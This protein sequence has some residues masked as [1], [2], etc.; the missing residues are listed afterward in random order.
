MSEAIWFALALLGAWMG[1]HAISA[2]VVL[3][4]VLRLQLWPCRMDWL[5]PPAGL[6]EDQFAAVDEVKA[7]GFRS[8]AE[9]T[10][11]VGPRRYGSFLFRH[12]D[13]PVFAQLSLQAGNTAGYPLSFHSFCTDGTEL[14]TVNRIGWLIMTPLPRQQRLDAWAD[15]LDAHWK[16]HQ[17]RLANNTVDGITDEAAQH[18]IGAS[19]ESYFPLLRERGLLV[20]EAGAWHPRLRT[21]AAVTWRWLKIRSHFARPYA[22]AATSDAH[23][24]AFYTSSYIET[25][26]ALASRPARNNVKAMLLVLTAAASLLLWGST[27]NWQAGLAL[28]VILLLHEGGHALAMRAFG[29]RDLTMFF[30]P[31]IG[32]VVTGTPRPLPAWKQAVVLLAG[33]VP[34]MLIGLAMLLWW[35]PPL[36]GFDWPRAATLAVAVNLFNLLPVTPLDG[37]RLVELSLFSRWPRLRLV[38]AA[39][40]VAALA[41]LALWSKSPLMWVLVIALGFGLLSQWRIAQLQRAWREG[42]SQE[43]QLPHL[44]EAARRTFGSQG[45]IRQYGLVKAVLTQRA[46]AIPRAWESVVTLSILLAL[47]TT[48][49]VAAYPW[50][51]SQSSRA[52]PVGTAEQQAF[53]RAYETFSSDYGDDRDKSLKTLR[54]QAARLAPEDPRQVDMQIVLA[55]EAEG[56]KRQQAYEAVLAARKNGHAEDLESIQR[57]MLNEVY[58]DHHGEAPQQRAAALEAAI[59]RAGELMPK[60]YA[61]TVEGRLRLAEAIDQ[62]GDAQRA[63]SM[64]AEIRHRVETADDCRCEL[65]KVLSAQAWFFLGQNRPADAITM[66]ESSSH[67]RNLK[68]PNGSLADEYAWALLAAGRIDEGIAQMRIAAYSEASRPGLRQR[69]QG[70]KDRPAELREP[71][72]LAYALR[73]GGRQQEAAALLSPSA[74]W[75]C[76]RILGDQDSISAYTEPW[77]QP[78]ERRLNDTARAICP[79]N[80]KPEDIWPES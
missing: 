26:A 47:W 73:R 5:T 28:L 53:D 9:G 10:V 61:A 14:L 35:T 13:L 39:L 50:L 58:N 78:R 32:A 56:A 8:I 74:L 59:A 11:E 72:D 79:K 64:L 33:P 19:S 17:A 23:Q 54:Q 65:K 77:Q 36:S 66:L 4:Q 57:E 60:Q 6:S 2:V 45:F 44:F 76:A 3:V 46:I 31:F 67:A 43:Q 75:A 24:A 41:A 55:R 7:L 68:K 29:Y 62:A 40:S 30:I 34:G 1:I 20:Q 71:L 42:L 18:R 48:A 63:E 80:L 25:D 69:L 51:P 16:A 21:A 49:G 37:G 52:H 38:F 22:C 15:D 27:I 12:A 70:R